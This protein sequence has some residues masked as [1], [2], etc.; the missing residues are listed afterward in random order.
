MNLAAAIA[1]A[2]GGGFRIAELALAAGE[3]FGATRMSRASLFFI[4]G[5]VIHRAPTAAKLLSMVPGDQ[6]GVLVGAAKN[7]PWAEHFG[8]RPLFFTLNLRDPNCPAAKLRQLELLCPV[9]PD[10][11][12]STPLLTLGP[13]MAP[14]TQANLWKAL[15]ALWLTFLSAVVAALYSWHSF[16]VGLACSLLAAGAPGSIILALCRWRSAASLRIYARLNRET[17]GQWIGSAHTQSLSSL[18]GSHLPALPGA[19]PGAS[20]A[21]AA[22]PGALP[23]NMYSFLDAAR[24]GQAAQLSQDQFTALVSRIPEMDPDEF[25]HALSRLNLGDIDPD[26]VDPEVNDELS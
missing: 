8:P 1:L 17:V 16:R 15:H 5:G 9:T 14:M 10:K 19:V 25:V 4:I 6:T 22:V 3:L 26:F 12:R 24:A 11:R 23:G 21:H 20:P 18:Q 2:S 7:D 13:N